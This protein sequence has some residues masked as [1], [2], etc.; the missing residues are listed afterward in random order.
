MNPVEREQRP[1]VSAREE[2]LRLLED[3]LDGRRDLPA[4]LKERLL[5]RA[6]AFRVTR[7]RRGR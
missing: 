5:E 6:R 3:H 7:M 2:F 1:R 4:E